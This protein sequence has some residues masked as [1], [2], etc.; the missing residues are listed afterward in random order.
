[1]AEDI[2][3]GT[4][5]W[6]KLLAFI[7]IAVITVCA[8]M[9]VVGDLSKPW[10]AATQI[11]SAIAGAGLG[12]ILSAD[13]TRRGVSNHV[14]PSIRRLYDQAT[15]LRILVQRVE[16][17]AAAIDSGDSSRT[18]EKLRRASDQFGFIGHQLRDEITSTASAI[19]DWGDL[20]RSV[21]QAE[22]D[23]YQERNSQDADISPSEG[24]RP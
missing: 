17:T 20:S 19:E 4:S 22:L 1:M 2:T 15:R 13:F 8:I 7:L 6:R 12:S 21:Y 14:R 18:A 11:G 23:R 3:G 9:I 24:P 10:T 16:F 5:W